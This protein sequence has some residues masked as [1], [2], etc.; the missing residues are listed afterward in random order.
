MSDKKRSEYAEK[1]RDP[2]WQQK[3]LLIM[4]RDNWACQICF[5]TENTLNVHHRYYEF[6]NDPWDYPDDALVTLCEDCHRGETEQLPAV[7]SLLMKALTTR[8]FAGDILDLAKAFT[9]FKGYFIPDVDAAAIAWLLL[10]DEEYEA[11]VNKYFA[12][13]RAKREQVTP[14]PRSHRDSKRPS[15]TNRGVR[16]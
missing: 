15:R 7:K 4:E 8:F 6:G 16:L 13:M 1:F 3:R 9:L 10:N 12:H 14:Q 2:R 5:D 11:V